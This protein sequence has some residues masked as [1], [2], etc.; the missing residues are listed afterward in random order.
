MHTEE[1]DLLHGPLI[2]RCFR[3]L[4][5]DISDFSFA[6][7]YLFRKK[8]NFRLA[9]KTQQVITCTT[10][11]GEPCWMPLRD[12]RLLERRD[13]IQLMND[14]GTL[15]PAP[16]EWMEI[17]RGGEFSISC[18]ESEMDYLYRVEKMATFEGSGLTRKR[19]RLKQF[20]SLYEHDSALLTAYRRDEAR[21]V[22]DDWQNETALSREETDY[23]PCLEAL[24]LMDELKLLGIIHYAEMRPVGFLI[25]EKLWGRTFVIHF[26]KGIKRYKGLYE[27]MFND[28]ANRLTSR[29]DY[30]NLEEDL[31]QEAL[32][33]A[34]SS[35]GPDRMIRKYRV[36]L[37]T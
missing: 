3:A 6:S 2:R 19:N 16:E 25:G 27:Y 18:R 20:L 33:V 12:L 23:D 26:A 5:T 4:K 10:E 24:R 32:R 1:L 21:Q 30:L 35:Y 22:L 36:R 7:V 14:H 34:K 31:G 9:R 11:E 37:N 15:F 13:V 28:A 29:Y 17:F 8:W